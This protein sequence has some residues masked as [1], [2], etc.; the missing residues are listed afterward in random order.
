MARQRGASSLTLALAVQVLVAL[1]AF[2]AVAG[3]VSF[4]RYVEESPRFCQTCHNVAPEIALWMESEHRQ[5]RCQQCH[6]QT[7]EDGLRIL[8]VFVGGGMPEQ[9][10]APVEVTS[11]ATCHA[12]HDERWPSIANSSGHVVHV[13]KEKLP[14]TACHGAQMHFDRPARETCLGCHKDMTVG[15]AHEKRHCLAC[16]NFLSTEAVV[17]PQRQDCLRCHRNQ[18]KPVVVSPTAPMQ[19][20]CSA[21]H[22]PH[23]EKGVVDCNDCHKQRELGGLHDLAGH[24]KCSDCHEQ[25]EWTSTKPQ[26]FVCHEGMYSHHPEQ[27]CRK[28]HVFETPL[29]SPRK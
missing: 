4:R 7:L 18:A 22:R 3:F 10:H 21:C 6:H 13:Q 15:S 27:A 17:R 12:S 28:C 5:V 1:A 16:H 20:A 23:S 11:C 2:A 8:Q 9:S 25:H 26:C 19:F 24:Q 14:C 29:G